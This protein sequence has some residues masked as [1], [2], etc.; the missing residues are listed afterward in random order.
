MLFTNHFLCNNH[1]PLIELLTLPLW[2]CILFMTVVFFPV[3]L[4]F[5]MKWTCKNK[6]KRKERS[7]VMHSLLP[8]AHVYHCS[9]W[10]NPTRNVE[11]FPHSQ[12]DVAWQSADAISAL[13]INTYLHV[14]VNAG[15]DLRWKIR[16]I[17]SQMRRQVCNSTA[18]YSN[19]KS[20]EL[21]CFSF[22]CFSSIQIHFGIKLTIGY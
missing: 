12:Q 13:L 1:F 5:S 21:S 22:A 20:N 6:K 7:S 17:N 15:N 11:L 8:S 9:H 14:S 18:F 2:H 16:K 10:P 4:A 3:G 19:S